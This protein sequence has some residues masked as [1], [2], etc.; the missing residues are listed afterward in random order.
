MK[1][2]IHAEALKAA[3]LLD[4]DVPFAVYPEAVPSA[5]MLDEDGGA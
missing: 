2:D 1:F 5:E 3:W 4:E